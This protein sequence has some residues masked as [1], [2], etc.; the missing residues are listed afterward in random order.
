MN[1]LMPSVDRTSSILDRL[2]EAESGDR[3]SIGEIMASL[4]GRAFALL[5]VLLG[6]PNSL[7]MPPPIALI[8]G[9]LVAFLAF[10]LMLGFRV[11]WLP[12]RV[13]RLT[14]G[15]AALD[16]TLKRARPYVVAMERL[17]R[18]RLSMFDT[19]VSMR[20]VGLLLLLL[21]IAMIVAV[22]VIGQIPLG[23]AVC[24]I[25]L[26]LVERDGVIVIGGLL[27]GAVGVAISGSVVV[28]FILGLL[29]VV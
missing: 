4:Q 11:P 1:T 17:S 12:Q 3:V 5:L 15:R 24:L 14:V 7:P 23:I 8:S 22:P 10:Q 29:N 25:G 9:F 19:A 2:T 20:I 18:P 21:S 13:Q 16:A 28:A 6:L 27:V 26:G